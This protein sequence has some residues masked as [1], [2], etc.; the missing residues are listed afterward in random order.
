M[1][2]GFLTWIRDHKDRKGETEGHWA[3]A[4]QAQFLTGNF[5][6]LARLLDE[7]YFLKLPF[8]NKDFPK[9]VPTQIIK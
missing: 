7:N 2:E 1:L 8:R 9:Y 3:V 5:S 4:S 6:L